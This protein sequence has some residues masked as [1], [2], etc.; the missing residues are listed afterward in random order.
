ML[1]LSYSPL[2]WQPMRKVSKKGPCTR[3]RCI[4][5][6]H[7][8][9]SNTRYS[10]IHY[11]SPLFTIYRYHIRRG[12][13]QRVESQYV[14]ARPLNRARLRSPA[15]GDPL[16]TVSFLQSSR[17]AKLGIR[18]EE[19]YE[20][21]VGDLIQPVMKFPHCYSLLALISPGEPGLRKLV[22]LLRARIPTG[23][24]WQI[25]PRQSP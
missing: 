9:A 6:R 25:N 17:S 21:A 20:A 10:P 22:V 24:A 23:V 3:R 5:Y 15:A 18:E 7:Y 2:N 8:E 11:F 1:P 16:P 4:A 19:F 14:I 13:Y 12:Q